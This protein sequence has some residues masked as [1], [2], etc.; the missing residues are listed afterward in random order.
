MNIQQ[1]RAILKLA[2]RN[3]C[4]VRMAMNVC[5]C[6]EDI[7][8]I[9]ALQ[10][11]SLPSHYRKM[12]NNNDMAVFGTSPHWPDAT[13]ERMYDRTNKRLN[14]SMHTRCSHQSIIMFNECNL[15]A[16]DFVFTCCYHRTT[17]RSIH[18]TRPQ[19]HWKLGT[20]LA[21]RR[22]KHLEGRK[23]L[24]WSIRMCHS[25]DRSIN[26]WI[27]NRR[28]I[29]YSFSFIANRCNSNLMAKI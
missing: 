27:R 16:I 23:I 6:V 2:E 25:I 20:Q 11:C 28:W 9:N 29:C 21:V 24:E 5:L 17:D 10:T 7:V 26:A 15:M 1:F 13:D 3:Q 8:W 4:A 19:P 22:G 18:T 12:K 14:K